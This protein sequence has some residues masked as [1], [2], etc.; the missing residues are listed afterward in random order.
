MWLRA[1]S[2][3]RKAS[4]GQTPNGSGRVVIAACYSS[5][6]DLFDLRLR[7][8]VRLA[9][10]LCQHCVGWQRRQGLSDVNARLVQFENLIFRTFCLYKE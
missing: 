4:F 8:T 5:F 3:S 7:S 1:A 9:Q 2:P 6:I 10:P